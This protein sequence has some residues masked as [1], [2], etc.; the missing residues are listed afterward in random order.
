MRRLSRQRG[1]CIFP[2]Q[3]D[4]SVKPSRS[5]TDFPLFTENIPI[6][7][8]KLWSKTRI[9]TSRVRG[10]WRW[11]PNFISFYISLL[12]CKQ[13][14]NRWTWMC[15]RKAKLKKDC[16]PSSFFKKSTNILVMMVLKAVWL[17]FGFDKE[18]LVHLTHLAVPFV[19]DF[20][21]VKDPQWAVFT[22]RFRIQFV[23]Q[24]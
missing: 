19:P 17:D 5:A 12:K 14:Q 20:A 13:W 24:N 7:Q 4:E 22:S 1:L 18:S 11:T 16:E 23:Q 21:L 9:L 10:H 8:L 6:L 15:R 3:E 2:N